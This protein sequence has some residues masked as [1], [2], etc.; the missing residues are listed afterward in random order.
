MSTY[1]KELDTIYKYVI[2]QYNKRLA[3]LGKSVMV[4]K[5][6]TMCD[7]I[8]VSP[9]DF[10]DFNKNGPIDDQV[11][12]IVDDGD[13]VKYDIPIGKL[14][15]SCY[16]ND[17]YCYKVQI[18][19]MLDKIYGKIDEMITDLGSVDVVVGHAPVVVRLVYDCNRGH[20]IALA[21]K[22]SIGFYT[23]S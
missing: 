10:A 20:D 11:K 12:K 7:N 6:K 2:K 5:S 22:V 8:T 21:I 17:D 23:K 16:I 1:T 13:N 15:L 18:D 3:K 9:L 14:L 4:V 19:D